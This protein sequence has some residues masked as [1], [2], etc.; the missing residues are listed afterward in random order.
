MVLV[1]LALNVPGANLADA[2]TAEV[3]GGFEC[4]LLLLVDPVADAATAVAAPAAA[5]VIGGGLFATTGWCALPWLLAAAV[6][7]L[8]ATLGLFVV[9][10]PAA[11]SMEASELVRS[12]PASLAL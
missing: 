9:V 11:T 3:C 7:L 12:S 8:F 6:L 5:A 4:S 10:I 1:L 2:C